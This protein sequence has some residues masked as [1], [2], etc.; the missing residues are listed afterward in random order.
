M[1]SLYKFNLHINENSTHAPNYHNNYKHVMD[2]IKSLELFHSVEYESSM[3]NMKYYRLQISDN[4]D[5]LQINCTYCNN[6]G[7]RV[8][9][10]NDSNN[11]CWC[12]GS[13]NYY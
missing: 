13:D 4:S 2:E 10:N 7:E 9:S 12:F 5:R 3:Y 6:C 1:N 8:M 11:Y